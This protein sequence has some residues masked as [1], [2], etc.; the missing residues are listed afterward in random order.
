FEL[1]SLT[2]INV[3]NDDPGISFTSGVYTTGAGIVY[4]S[5][6]NFYI[7]D[8]GY[9]PDIGQVT[10][11]NKFDWDGATG[12]VEFVAAGFVPGQMLNQFSADEYAGHLRIATSISNS[13]SGNWSGQSENAMFVVKE[14]H[15]TLE[16]VGSMQNLALNE[17]IQSVRYFGDRAYVVTYRQI[18]PLFAIDLSDQTNP[19]AVGSL[20][21]PGFSTYMQFISEDRLLA[22]GRNTP[23]G[24]NGPAMVSLFDVSS[25]AE[26]SLIDQFTFERFSI[27]EAGVDHHAFGYFASHGILALPSAKGYIQRVDKDGDG[28]RETSQWTEEHELLVFAIDATVVGRNDDGIE[29]L[30]SIQHDS[31]VRR[32]GYIGEYLYSVANDSVN[33]VRIEQPDVIVGTVDDLT[34]VE[35]EP[36]VFVDPV[37]P[38]IE[39]DFAIAAVQND[40]AARLGIAAGQVL[41]VTAERGTNDQLDVVVRVD[42]QMFL[43]SDAGGAL[44]L[45]EVGFE[46]DAGQGW[47]NSALPVD[48][49]GDG[50]VAP[51]DALLIIS[52]LNQNGSHALDS[53]GL[54]RAISGGEKNNW[55]DVNNDGYISPIDVLMITNRLAAETRLDLPAIDNPSS[56]NSELI[57]SVFDGVLNSIGDS[58]LDG[59]FDSGDLVLAFQAGEYEDDVAG[60]STWS[61]GDWNGDLE[62]STADL[63]LAFQQGHY[64]AAAVDA[65]HDESPFAANRQVRNVDDVFAELLATEDQPQRWS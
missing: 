63:V 44:S 31:A 24:F 36:P 17:S 26:P 33:A 52:E 64:V 23:N 55:L 6:D 41:P 39:G 3:L 40:L 35:I 37:W 51:N 47:H 20:T 42:D 8:N 54:V 46:F 38:F 5:L 25:L 53:S 22:V 59:R 62:F 11:V 9:E 48:V 4:A 18:D 28:F 32:S 15:G 65:T 49:N 56:A 19:Q 34:K 10:R 16:Y 21:L 50:Q 60:N 7:F 13:G 30:S 2:S 1:I 58:N 14:D 57:D 27:S 43:Y 29:L 12:G 45:K 61:D